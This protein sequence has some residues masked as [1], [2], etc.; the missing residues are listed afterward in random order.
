M[1]LTCHLASLAV[2]QFS[3][4]SPFK[5]KKKKRRTNWFP[6]PTVASASPHG[7]VHSVL[8]SG[9]AW[10]NAVAAGGHLVRTLE[11]REAFSRITHRALK[12]LLNTLRFNTLKIISEGHSKSP[13]SAMSMEHHIRIYG[14]L[15]LTACHI[16]SR[17][18]WGRP[19][20]VERPL[21]ATRK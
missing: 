17:C 13:G 12:Q 18:N 16:F 2:P 20:A 7:A 15:I 1:A 21:H 14:S 3:T 9:S 19:Y 8:L 5:K 11:E 10:G 4:N 6:Y